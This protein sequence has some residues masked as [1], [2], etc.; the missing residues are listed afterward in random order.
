M[1]IRRVGYKV[2]FNTLKEGKCRVC[3]TAIPGIWS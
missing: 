2:L 1:V 3:G